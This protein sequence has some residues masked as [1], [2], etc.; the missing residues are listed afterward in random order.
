MFRAV[1]ELVKIAK[2]ETCF[3]FYN[4]KTLVFKSTKMFIMFK[5]LFITTKT[6]TLISKVPETLISI[7]F[8]ILLP[9]PYKT[10]TRCRQKSETQ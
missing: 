7:E 2:K 8:D 4:V 3:A 10:V 9:F 5:T 6:N 1:R